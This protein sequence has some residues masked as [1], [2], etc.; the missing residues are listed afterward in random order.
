MMDVGHWVL[1]VIFPAIFFIRILFA[2]RFSIAETLPW[3]GPSSVADN[4]I[5]VNSNTACA[6]WGH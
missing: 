4:D 1:A 5:R 6:P 2:D 3:V